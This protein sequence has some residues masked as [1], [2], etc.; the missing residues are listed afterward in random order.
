MT[1]LFHT[2]LMT[3]ETATVRSYEA[4][5]LAARCAS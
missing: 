4:S 2:Q 1:T 3:T 5:A